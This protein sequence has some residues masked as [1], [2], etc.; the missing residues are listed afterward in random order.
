MPAGRCL[1]EIELSEFEL[2]LIELSNLELLKVNLH[3]RPEKGL[4]KQ[5]IS[6]L[7]SS[8]EPSPLDLHYLLT[9]L[10]FSQSQ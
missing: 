4:S 5:C 3:C 1:A 7:D 6:R 2:S 9:H 8:W 10:A